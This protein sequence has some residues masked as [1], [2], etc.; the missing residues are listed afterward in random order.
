M[1]VSQIEKIA[2]RV[3]VFIVV[4]LDGKALPIDVWR[5]EIPGDAALAQHASHT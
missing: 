3:V 1:K 2:E 4:Y 5:P